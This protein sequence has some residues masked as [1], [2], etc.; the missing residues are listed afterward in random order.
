MSRTPQHPVRRCPPCDTDWPAIALYN[1]CP[2]CQKNTHA[3]TA[4]AR[5]DYPAAFKI[6]ERQE[7]IREFDRQQDGIADAAAKAEIAELEKLFALPAYGVVRPANYGLA[8]PRVKPVTNPQAV[9][10]KRYGGSPDA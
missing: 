8:G 4:D 6:C 1:L 9:D 3:S 5:P 7:R 2:Y 10:F